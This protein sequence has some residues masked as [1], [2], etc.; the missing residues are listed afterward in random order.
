ML[1][2]EEVSSYSHYHGC[3]KFA[4]MFRASARSL[5]VV[6][7]ASKVANRFLYH[8]SDL[9]WGLPLESRGRFFMVMNDC[10]L[11]KDIPM[12]NV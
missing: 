1:D 3:A 2:A 12:Y 9:M 5:E 10:A 7:D 6:L 4:Q 11:R 8:L